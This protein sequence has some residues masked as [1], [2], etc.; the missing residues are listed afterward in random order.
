M[1]T[2]PIPT[3]EIADNFGSFVAIGF[4]N[5]LISVG[6]KAI[7]GRVPIQKVA[8]AIIPMNGF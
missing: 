4:K 7:A 2:I 3:N 1:V 8:I 5:F 6:A